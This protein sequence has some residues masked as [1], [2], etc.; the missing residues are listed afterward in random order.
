LYEYN[1]RDRSPSVDEFKRD[2]TLSR[3]YKKKTIQSNQNE[4]HND[5]SSRRATFHCNDNLEKTT[6]N[7]DPQQMELRLRQAALVSRM[8]M[9]RKQSKET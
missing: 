1:C 7:E 8:K 5:Q 9:Q 6:Q 2:K 3:L 4:V